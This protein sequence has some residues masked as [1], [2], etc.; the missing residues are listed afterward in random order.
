MSYFH[1][2]RKSEI[3]EF[4]GI[5]DSSV[6]RKTASFRMTAGAGWNADYGDSSVGRE[7]ASFRMTAHCGIL[8]MLLLPVLAR[9]QDSDSL[10]LH[11]F[12]RQALECNLELKAVRS[13]ISSARSRVRQSSAYPEPRAGVEFMGTP[14]S[15]ANF[16]R[17]AEEKRFFIEQMIPFPG[18]LSSASAMAEAGVRVREADAAS[19]ERTVIQNVKKGYIM[20][21]AAQR[22][23]RVNE[24]SQELLRNMI[25]SAEARYGVGLSSQADVLRLNVELDR[26]K[27]ER[28]TLQYDL[29][30][31]MGMLNILRAQPAE[32]EIGALPEW[33]W[34]QFDFDPDSL[35][36]IAKSRRP[37]LQSMRFALDEMRAELTM[38]RRERLPDFMVGGS[39]NV[40]MEMENRW[41]LMVGL[42]LPFAPW[43]SDKFSGRVEEIEYNFHSM[44]QRLAHMEYMARFDVYD[45]WSRAKAHWESTERIRTSIIPKAEQAL[46]SILALYQTRQADF[47]SLLD[48]YRMVNMERMNLYMEMSDHLMQVF[49]L[50]R[51]VGEELGN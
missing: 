10:S 32:T 34:K 8:V 42:S 50:E 38:A 48:A 17:D 36:A 45:T 29:T 37:E 18:K 46:Q 11:S 26:L 7:S 41:Q 35:A 30:I 4:A 9:A 27:N 6:G 3:P 2:H 21:Y 25:A 43:A 13:G 15:S 19:I 47:I 49:D 24:D 5:T 28:A 12:I 51:A 33:D 23:I 16:I 39:Y 40:M 22:R 14:V 31:P 44:E 1:I 20:M